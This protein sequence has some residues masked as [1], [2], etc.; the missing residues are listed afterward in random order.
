MSFLQRC[1]ISSV[2]LCAIT[3]TALAEDLTT[4]AA[5]KFAIGSANADPG[6]TQVLPTNAFPASAGY[7]FEGGSATDLVAHGS[8]EGESHSSILG[9][10]AFFFSARVPGE[11]NYRVTVT[12]G[13]SKEECT[14]TIKAELR[15]SMVEKIHT[16]V[17]EFKTVSFIVN[18][19]TPKITAVADIKAGQVKLKA[20]RETTQEAW[21]WDDLLTLEFDGTRPA[22]SRLEITRAE[23]PTVFLIGDSTVCD[24]SRLSLTRVGARCCPGFSRRRWPSR[25]TRSPV[26]LIATRLPADAWT[27]F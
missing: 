13:D 6:C 14:T 10:Q 7:G 12:L 17:N 15:R 8:G 19:R 1:I 25:T 4:N 5:L 18:V 26:R 3:L 16:A 21:A 23:V 2:A 20:P 9:N 24:Q 22:I 11:G 27:R